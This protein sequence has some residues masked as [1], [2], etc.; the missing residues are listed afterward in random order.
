MFDFADWD[1][2]LPVRIS[3]RS[4]QS[5][6]PGQTPGCP[7]MGRARNW[8][9]KPVEPLAKLEATSSYRV[10][11]GESREVK[12]RARAGHLTRTLV[13]GPPLTRPSALSVCTQR[14]P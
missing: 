7:C 1:Y 10:G 6:A 9:Q 14:A 13:Q 2:C 4:T 3:P 5:K 11:F 8:L 12:L